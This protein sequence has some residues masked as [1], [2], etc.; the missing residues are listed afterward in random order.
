MN[1]NLGFVHIDIGRNY[2]VL[3]DLN[4]AAAAFKR[5]TEVDAGDAQG[6]VLYG[7]VVYAQGDYV[8]ATQAFQ[9]AIEIDPEYG[10]AHARLGLAFY[11]RRN[12]EDAI[13]HLERGISLGDRAEENLVILGLCLSYLDECERAIPWFEE[14]LE[15]NP[16]SPLA[17]QGLASCQ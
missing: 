16:S 4:S 2:R 12:W 7:S 10:V 3:T 6:Y 14:A 15:V 17:K 8:E 9:R 11:M 1:P 5:S 13:V